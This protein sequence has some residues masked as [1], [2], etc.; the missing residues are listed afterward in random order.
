M[1]LFIILISM[2]IW[3]EDECF[4]SWTDVNCI[5]IYNLCCTDPCLDFADLHSKARILS[6]NVYHKAQT[7]IKWHHRNGKLCIEGEYPDPHLFYV[8][9]SMG[10]EAMLQ[11]YDKFNIDF[12]FPD[13]VNVSTGIVDFLEHEKKAKSVKINLNGSPYF[14]RNKARY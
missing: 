1:W 5:R 12:E 14:L 3:F 10:F 7:E 6:Q 11:I 13:G 8:S 9:P 2:I 4:N